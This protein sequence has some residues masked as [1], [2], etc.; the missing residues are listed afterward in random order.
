MSDCVNI[1]FAVFSGSVPTMKWTQ[2]RWTGG[3]ERFYLWKYI[4]KSLPSIDIIAENTCKNVTIVP[5]SW[6]SD[7]HIKNL[8]V[9]INIC[10]RAK[11]K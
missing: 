9:E 4:P 3:A 2:L 8:S 11:S 5:D 1:F 6:D 7:E 10:K